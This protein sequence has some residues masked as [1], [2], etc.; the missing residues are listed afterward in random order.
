[1][2]APHTYYP[3]R[4]QSAAHYYSTGRPSYPPRLIQRVAELAGLEPLHRVLD[5]GTGPGFLAVDFAPYAVEVIGIDPSPEMLEVARR[6]AAA[7]DGKIRF[8]LGSSHDLGPGLGQFHLVV[9]GRAFHWMDRAKTLALLDGLIGPGGAVVL[10]SESHPDVP[11]NA[12]RPVFQGVMNRYNT[13]DP[14]RGQIRPG[15]KHEAVLLESRFNKLERV[16][17]YERRAT[18]LE[19]FGD[20]ALSYGSIWAGTPGLQPGEVSREVVSSLQKF[21]LDGVITEILAGEALIARRG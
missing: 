13:D 8:L 20:R 1:M 2:S 10:F 11:A 17:V 15:H 3:D 19:R 18:P 7:V 16:I 9:I 21:A 12:W 4:F 14:A 5:L 6:N